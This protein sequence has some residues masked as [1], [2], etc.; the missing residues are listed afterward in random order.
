MSGVWEYN[1]WDD[2]RPSRR[3]V[4][5]IVYLRPVGRTSR[6]YPWRSESR[7]SGSP[8]E[9]IP[10]EGGAGQLQEGYLEESNVDLV[11]ERLRLRFL[12]DWREMLIGAL[13]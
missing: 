6:N 2:P 13:K 5:A 3:L 7:E 1:A 4:E 10:G 12:N 11:R 9:S 8:I